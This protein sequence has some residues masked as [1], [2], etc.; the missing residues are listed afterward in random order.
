MAS[1]SLCVTHTQEGSLGFTYWVCW[2]RTPPAVTDGRRCRGGGQ[3]GRRLGPGLDLSAHSAADLL[4]GLG[5]SILARPQFAH[6]YN[7]GLLT[8][9]AC[10]HWAGQRNGHTGG[11]VC[12]GRKG[13]A[14]GLQEGSGHPAF[15][16]PSSRK[17]LS[18]SRLHSRCWPRDAAWPERV[19][20]SDNRVLGPQGCPG[21][22]GCPSSA[23]RCPLIP[24]VVL[25]MWGLGGRAPGVG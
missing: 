1:R 5:S 23:L 11:N 3:W 18:F 2:A 14:A 19:Q 17:H 22:S 21:A 8:A 25:A 15:A 10:R 6:M 16:S 24:G 4:R 20:A 7:E 9:R 13:G 12:M